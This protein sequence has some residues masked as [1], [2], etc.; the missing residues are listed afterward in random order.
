MVALLSMMGLLLFFAVGAF[1]IY[2][3]IDFIEY[4]RKYHSKRWAQLSFARLFGLSQQDVFFYQIHPLKFLPYLFNKEDFE[5][6][7]VAEYKKRIQ[8]AVYA[9]SAMIVISFITSLFD[10]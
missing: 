3:L 6:D 9:F 7:N 4:L 8:L 1:G 2:L 10:I 5:D